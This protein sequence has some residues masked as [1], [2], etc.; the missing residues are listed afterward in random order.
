M[1]ENP[2]TDPDDKR[3]SLT[4]AGIHFNNIDLGVLD[5]D[6]TGNDAPSMAVSSVDGE[7]HVLTS[8]YVAF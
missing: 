3:G 5:G 8:T 4:V 7:R 6:G 1:I 2:D